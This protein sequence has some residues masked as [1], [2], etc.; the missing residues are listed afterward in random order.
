MLITFEGIGTVAARQ[1]KFLYFEKKIEA[2][3]RI[4]RVFREP[5]GT[6]VSGKIRLML[7]D[8][9]NGYQIP[10]SEL[11][12]FSAARSQVDCFATVQTTCWAGCCC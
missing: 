12:L 8:P 10:V 7:L 1:R 4:V 11:L 5:G 6:A 3:S 9:E 2:F